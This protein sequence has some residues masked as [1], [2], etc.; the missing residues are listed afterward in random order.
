MQRTLVL[1]GSSCSDFYFLLEC[2][3]VTHLFVFGAKSCSYTDTCAYFLS[4]CIHVEPVRGCG[5]HV[6]I[7][8][9]TF[10]STFCL[11]VYLSV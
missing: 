11:L 6:L 4:T 3:W 8:R 5:I 7:L 1:G 2:S 10:L 9:S